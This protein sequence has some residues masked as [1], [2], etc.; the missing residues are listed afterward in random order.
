M[1]RARFSERRK[2]KGKSDAGDA[3]RTT[4]EVLRSRTGFRGGS[5]RRARTHVGGLGREVLRS[6]PIIFSSRRRVERTEEY[7]E[8]SRI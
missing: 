1:E 2:G 7:H 5:A 8:P 3:E 6:T 4:R